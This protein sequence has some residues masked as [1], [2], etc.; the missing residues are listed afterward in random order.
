MRN[1]L[2]AI[3]ARSLSSYEIARMDFGGATGLL[4]EVHC[5][6]RVA[7][8]AFERVVGFHP[9]P[10]ML[11]KLKAHVEKFLAGVDGAENLAPYLLGRLHFPRDLD[12]PF[13]RHVA[14]R[15]CRAHARSIGEMHRPLQFLIHVVLHLVTGDAK[16]LRIAEL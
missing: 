3:D 7:V 2:M 4:G 13:M 9:R 14:V 8:A 6:R 1:A 12:R 10:F 11:G 16:R 15:T 5:N